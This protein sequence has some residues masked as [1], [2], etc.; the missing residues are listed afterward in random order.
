[1]KQSYLTKLNKITELIF[2]DSDLI[3][4]IEKLKL[5]LNLSD[6]P[7][8]GKAIKSISLPFT[9]PD[10]IK[11]VWIFVIKKNTPSISH[12][13]PNSVQH[14]TVIEGCGKVMIGDKLRDLKSFDSSNENTW[15]II[16]KNLPHEFFPGN[17]DLVVLS[18]H[19][20]LPEDLI[21]VKSKSGCERKYVNEN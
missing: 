2:N 1:M 8:L 15:Y 16:D 10:E 19:S 18:F 4:I 21:E 5:E 9:L 3:G 13:H 20:C 14:T 17:E 12:Y 6:Q 11:S 7:F